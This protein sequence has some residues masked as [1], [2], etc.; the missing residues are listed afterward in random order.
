MKKGLDIAQWF[1]VNF[2][3]EFVLTFAS[4]FN[5]DSYNKLSNS[6]NRNTASY[7][8][9]VVFISF[10]VMILLMIPR[11]AYMRQSVEAGLDK[12]AEF[13]IDVNVTMKE[14]LYFRSVGLGIDSEHSRKLSYENILIDNETLQFRTC[15][16]LP[17]CN[18]FKGV[19]SVQ[20]DD[21]KNPLKKAD[22]LSGVLAVAFVALLPAILFGVFFMLL[23]KYSIM[24]LLF[25]VFGMVLLRVVFRRM[26]FV[27]L[28]RCAVYALTVMVVAEVVN[29][30][31]GFN[32]LYLPFFVSLLYFCVGVVNASEKAFKSS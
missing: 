9:S 2:P 31:L 29:I 28:L 26:K 23:V 14:P 18:L 24:A 13:T 16:M 3:M 4:V 27:K 5:P 10:C 21:Y 11:V 17:W 15:Y 32:L 8:F 22:E 25:G 12:F 20:L 7:L 1:K 30:A 6:S 19:H